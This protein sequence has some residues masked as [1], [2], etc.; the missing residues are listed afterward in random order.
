MFTN[1]ELLK[2]AFVLEIQHLI[3][4]I[5]SAESMNFNEIRPSFIDRLGLIG[6]DF[7]VCI[8][9]ANR[10]HQISNTH[11]NYKHNEDDSN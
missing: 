11:F 10:F 4:E 9:N 2:N 8:Q 1:D 7:L 6:G 3:H 5:D